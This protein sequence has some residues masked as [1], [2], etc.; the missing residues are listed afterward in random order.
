MGQELRQIH[1]DWLQQKDKEAQWDTGNTMVT[2]IP[3][4]VETPVAFVPQELLAATVDVRFPPSILQD[5][6][7]PTA[8]DDVEPSSETFVNVSAGTISSPSPYPT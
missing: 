2:E 1:H 3:T 8:L 5:I 7:L 6:S 4:E